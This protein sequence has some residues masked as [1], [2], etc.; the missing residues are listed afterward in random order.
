MFHHHIKKH[1]AALHN[2]VF[3]FF[4]TARP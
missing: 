3:H 4:G 1:I 2:K